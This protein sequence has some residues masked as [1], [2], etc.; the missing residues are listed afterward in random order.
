[1]NVVYSVINEN[2]EH[3][4][5]NVMWFTRS[6]FGAAALKEKEKA[7]REAVAAYE[8]VIE[9]N[10]PAKDEADNRIEKI[11]KDNWLLFEQAGEME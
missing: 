6:A 2:V 11:K 8:R 7:W 3:S 4:S 5:S 9:A 10:V 1:M